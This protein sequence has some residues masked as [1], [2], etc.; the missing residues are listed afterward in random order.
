MKRVRP[1]TKNRL[2]FGLALDRSSVAAFE[3]D[4]AL[5]EAVQHSRARQRIFHAMRSDAG[6][7]GV[8]GHNLCLDQGFS[9]RCGQVVW[10]HTA[11]AFQLNDAVAFPGSRSRSV[12][13][14]PPSAVAIIGTGLS[15]GC[16]KLGITPVSHAGATS[17]VAFSMNQPGRR[18][19]TAIDIERSDSSI[20]VRWVNRLDCTACAPT[21]DRQTTLAGFAATTGDL[22]ALMTPRAKNAERGASTE[23]RQVNY[24]NNLMGKALARKV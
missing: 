13:T 2:E 19:V 11:N 23:I 21:V 9:R 17:Q 15:R 1:G 8:T 12:A 5:T 20:M 14:Q 4:S 10:R 18:K 24:P 6:I 7:S 3:L 22:T 16:W